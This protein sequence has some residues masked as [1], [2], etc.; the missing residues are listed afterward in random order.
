MVIPGAGNTTVKQTGFTTL[1]LGAEAYA[2]SNGNG[3]ATS[4]NGYVVVSADPAQRGETIETMQ[5]SGLT[6]VV[7]QIIDGVDF[8]VTVEED[9]T[10]VPPHIGS[11]VS[12]VNPYVT[13][14]SWNVAPLGAN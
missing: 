7:T 9:A 6:A 8:R 11:I 12:A 4:G 10:L 5:G 1:V 14:G 3:G 2:V 13:A